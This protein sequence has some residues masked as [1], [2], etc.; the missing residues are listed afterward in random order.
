[1]ISHIRQLVKE[2]DQYLQVRFLKENINNILTN[3]F[4]MWTELEEKRFSSSKPI[5]TSLITS[6]SPSGDNQN[7][8]LE[9]ADWKAKLRKFRHEL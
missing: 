4:Q 8:A 9:L 1:M 2:R 6:I 3:Y 5:E 7:Y